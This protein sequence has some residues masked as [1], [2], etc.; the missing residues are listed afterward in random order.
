MD[1][2]ALNKLAKN[3][4]RINNLECSYTNPKVDYFF[5][6][7][8][9]I[10]KIFENLKEKF[11][12]YDLKGDGSS[13]PRLRI[14]ELEENPTRLSTTYKFQDDLYYISRRRKRINK[15]SLK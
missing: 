12:T 1:S 13:V 8:F 14:Y 4:K 15:G 7:K 5:G 2:W 9:F 6:G 11:I 3:V 10:I